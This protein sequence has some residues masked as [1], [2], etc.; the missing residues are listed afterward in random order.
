VHLK[1]RS[2]GKSQHTATSITTIIKSSAIAQCYFY[3]PAT[4][5]QLP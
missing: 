1:K 3:L 4:A 5:A 2:K